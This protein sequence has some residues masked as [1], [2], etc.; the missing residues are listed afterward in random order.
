[1]GVEAGESAS[2]CPAGY[3]VEVQISLG[4]DRTLWA[5]CGAESGAGSQRKLYSRSFDGG[6]SWQ[7]PRPGYYGGYSSK[8][9]AV[10]KQ[11]AWAA[12]VKY[13]LTATRNGGARWR[14]VLSRHDDAGWT[15][16]TFVD[17]KH[18]WAAFRYLV[19]KTVDGGTTWR[20]SLVARARKPLP[21]DI[22]LCP[23]ENSVKADVNGDGLEDLVSYNFIQKQAVLTVCTARG[24]TD[25]IHTSG[26]SELL[27]I[28]DIQ[29]DGQ[30][31]IL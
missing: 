3:A 27:E 29:E 19:L 22:G 17:A 20:Q 28:V 8:L 12:G 1:M 23:E 24:S 31:E 6:G 2:P 14:I 7:R 16:V 15:D 21:E 5:L 13:P 10:S 30:A 4:F 26:M 18:G 11:V 9:Q 25:R